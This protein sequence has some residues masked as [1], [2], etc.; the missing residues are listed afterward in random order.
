MII[1]EEIKFTRKYYPSEASFGWFFWGNRTKGLKGCYK[2]KEILEMTTDIES[3][4]VIHGKHLLSYTTGG[5]SVSD[6]Y[7]IFVKTRDRKILEKLG[8]M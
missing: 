5:S 3:Y 8:G 6:A 2:D 4:E 1:E 7:P